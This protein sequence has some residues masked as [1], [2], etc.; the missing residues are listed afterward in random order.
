MNTRTYFLII[1]RSFPLRMRNVSDKSCTENQNTYCMFSN[2]SFRKSCRLW[3]NVGKY[4]TTGLAI[5]D[6]MASYAGYL[7][8]QIHTIRLCN[9]YCLFTATTAAQTSPNVTLYVH[10]LSCLNDSLFHFVII[11]FIL[12]W[13][14]HISIYSSRSVCLVASH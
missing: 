14:I 9:T 5:D 2:Y 10:C 4:C 8:L 7:R 6:N 13:N 12:F 11:L 1:S 3:D